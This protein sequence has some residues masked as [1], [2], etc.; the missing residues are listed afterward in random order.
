MGWCCNEWLESMSNK[1][2]KWK[3]NINKNVLSGSGIAFKLISEDNNNT[4]ND[5]CT[6]YFSFAYTHYNYGA[7]KSH[8]HSIHVCMDKYSSNPIRTYKERDQ[9]YTH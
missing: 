5:N 6:G 3:F 2:I 7:V 1:I 8:S 9:I 4:N